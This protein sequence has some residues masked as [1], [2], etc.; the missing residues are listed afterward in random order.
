MTQQE[1]DLRVDTRFVGASCE[2][3]MWFGS[4]EESLQVDC[5]G[6]NQHG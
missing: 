1:L 2:G 4:D 5:K 6:N 3:V